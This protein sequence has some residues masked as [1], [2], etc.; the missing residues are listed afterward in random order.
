MADVIVSRNKNGI[1]KVVYDKKTTGNS[2]GLKFEQRILNLIE[3]TVPMILGGKSFRYATDIED[4]FQGTDCFVTDIPIDIT[5]AM[6]EKDFMVHSGIKKQFNEFL[7]SYGVRC[8]TKKFPFTKPV[9]VIGFG[10]VTGIFINEENVEKLILQISP[11][12]GEI[13]HLGLSWYK[14][15]RGSEEVKKMTKN[16]RVDISNRDINPHIV[17]HECAFYNIADMTP[18]YRVTVLATLET[19]FMSLSQIKGYSEES[20]QILTLRDLTKKYVHMKEDA[21]FWISLAKLVHTFHRCKNIAIFHDSP[22]SIN[23]R[24]DVLLEALVVNLCNL[25]SI[26]VPNWIPSSPT[27]LHS[28]YVPGDERGPAMIRTLSCT[29]AAFYERNII[30]DVSPFAPETLDKIFCDD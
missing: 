16:G 9:L 30:I 23:E 13:I 15:V 4:T 21:E 25:E 7:V 2:Y 26:A 14:S 11:R 3:T 22:V 8:R 28:P 5:L 10:I 24:I 27:R 1:K 29:P 12:I 17:K 6:N 20:L 18:V 19:Q